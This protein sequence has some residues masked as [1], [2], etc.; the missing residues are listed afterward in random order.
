MAQYLLV[1]CHVTV[2]FVVMGKR[3][4]GILLLVF[5]ITSQLD[6]QNVTKA[7]RAEGKQNASAGVFHPISKY[8]ERGN[9]DCLSA[10]FSENIRLEIMG[11]VSNCSKQQAKQILKEFFSNFTPRSFKFIYKSGDYPMEYAVGNL[12]SGGNIFA[13]TVL[14]SSDSTGSF[15]QH[16]KISKE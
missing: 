16:I 9:V 10:W 6:A 8:I 1:V 14:V 13:V 2:P 4:I 15:I 11:G 5:A 3:I 7:V 12:D